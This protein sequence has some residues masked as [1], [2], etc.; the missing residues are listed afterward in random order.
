VLPR[1]TDARPDQDENAVASRHDSAT[2]DEVLDFI[3]NEFGMPSA[4]P[5]NYP[6]W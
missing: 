4:G 5:R 6:C 3:E 2:A 1:W